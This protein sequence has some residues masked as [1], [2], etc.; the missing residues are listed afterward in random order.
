MTDTRLRRRGFKERGDIAFDVP[1][2]P[3]T[4]RRSKNGPAWVVRLL[5]NP[6]WS[7]LEGPR[8]LQMKLARLTP[9]AVGSAPV[10][11]RAHCFR[12]WRLKP[13]MGSFGF[14]QDVSFQR[15][16]SPNNALTTQMGS[17][18]YFP[19]FLSLSDGNWRA[20]CFLYH[21]LQS[22]KNA[23]HMFADALSAS[24]VLVFDRT[25][26]CQPLRSILKN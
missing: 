19:G 25:G 11:A 18:F 12:L 5:T 10:L 23:V 21:F 2:T 9:P 16:R 4:H 13:W 26:S 3:E 1:N 24:S 14:S 7:V 17:F 20:P 8:P 22:L 6:F 15:K